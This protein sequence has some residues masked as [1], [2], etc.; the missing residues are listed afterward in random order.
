MCIHP[1]LPEIARGEWGNNGIICTDG[2]ALT[3]L[4]NAHK[5][6]PTR[7]EGVAAIVKNTVGQILDRSADEAREALQRG[8][9]TEADIDRAIRGNIYV[10][11]RLGMLDDPEQTQNPYA[12]IG[13]DTTRRLHRRVSCC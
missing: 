9:I 3:L 13:K 1:C 8:L 2:S 7:A 10:A 12:T 6:F 4:I 5:A 11:L